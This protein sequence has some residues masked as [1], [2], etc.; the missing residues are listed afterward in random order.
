MCGVHDTYE[1]KS[2]DSPFI[3]RIYR[4][5][6]RNR[7]QVNA[8]VALLVALK[9]ANV[10]VSYPVADKSGAL[11]QQLDA[12]E[13][14]RCAVLFSYAPGKSIRTLSG[15]QLQSLGYE[16]ARFHNVSSFIHLSD[17]RW[18][19]DLPTII[20]QP[21]QRLQPYFTEDQ[22]GYEWL[23]EAAKKVEQQVLKTNIDKLTKGYCHF[24]FLPKNMHFDGDAVTFFDFDFMG[25]GWLVLDIVSFWQ[26]LALE[27]YARRMSREEGDQAYL[28]F[29]NAYRQI[30]PLNKEELS[31]VPYLSIGF[32]LFYMGFHITHDQ[33][34]I[35]SQ[36]VQL[37][38]YTG[39]LK[40][41]AGNYWH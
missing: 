11:V 7:S 3:L 10:A 30:R 32:W 38:L 28:T 31:L 23:Q 1:V 34:R 15:N 17:K 26:H 33:F 6:H 13:G 18:M 9:H 16:M 25:Y 22:E 36:P 19:F 2:A 12:I 20:F 39:I 40:Y 29:L 24:D 5:S 41:I 14:T 8:E 27:V 35:Y 37:K 4:N 21:L